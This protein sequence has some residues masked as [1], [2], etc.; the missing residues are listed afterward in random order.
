M[1]VLIATHQASIIIAPLSLTDLGR[2]GAPSPTWLGARRVGPVLGC[3]PDCFNHLT[4]LI[5]AG[6]SWTAL[7]P[8]PHPGNNHPG[9]YCNSI[10]IITMACSSAFPKVLITLETICSNLCVL[11]RGG[12]NIPVQNINT[13]SKRRNQQTTPGPNVTFYTTHTGN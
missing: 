12:G 7:P 11:V 9:E 6:P 13:T 8:F 3:Q 1:P 5:V 4:P 2:L 10:P